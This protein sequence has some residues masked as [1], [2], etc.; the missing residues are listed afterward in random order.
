VFGET[1]FVDA[2]T[3]S[4]LSVSGVGVMNI[5]VRKTRTVAAVMRRGALT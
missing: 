3:V 5:P 2:C 4:G 1:T